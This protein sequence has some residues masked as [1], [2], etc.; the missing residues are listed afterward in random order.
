M[1]DVHLLTPFKTLVMYLSHLNMPGLLLSTY[2]LHIF[3][4]QLCEAVAGYRHH[5]LSLSASQRKCCWPWEKSLNR[6]LFGQHSLL[7]LRNSGSFDEITACSLW[8]CLQFMLP[9]LVLCDGLIWTSCVLYY[10]IVLSFRYCGNRSLSFGSLATISLL[11]DRR[12]STP[13]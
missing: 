9:S 3:N 12:I 13:Q 7:T 11:S 1:V 8:L 2:V 4:M 10:E 5:Q 6:W